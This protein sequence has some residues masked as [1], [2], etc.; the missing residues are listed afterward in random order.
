MLAE[1]CSTL[2]LGHPTPHTEL[3]TVVESISATLEL[4]RAVPANGRSFSL[5]SASDKQLVW[6]SPPAF[7]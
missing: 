3:D 5:R 6:V 2:A 4:N 7:G 1:Q